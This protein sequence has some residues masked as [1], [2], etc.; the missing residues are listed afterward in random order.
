ML[1]LQLQVPIF[2]GLSRKYRLDQ[3]KIQLNK[4]KYNKELLEQ[5]IDTEVKSTS[6]I[7]KNTRESLVFFK[8][9][10][11]LAEEVYEVTKIKYEQGMTSSFELTSTEQDRKQALTN[12]YVALYDVIVAKIDLLKATG[13]LHK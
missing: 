4:T 2:S 11:E 12:Y 6:T 9:N 13:Q 3:A 1:G 7:Y 5:S 8:E 10:M